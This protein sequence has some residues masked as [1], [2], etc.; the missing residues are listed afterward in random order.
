LDPNSAHGYF[1]KGAI[2]VNKGNMREAVEDLRLAISFDPS[3]ADALLQ[4][5]RVYVSSGQIS[6][7]AS[8]GFFTKYALQGKKKKALDEVTPQ[9]ETAAKGVEYLS[10]DMAHGYAMIDEKDKALDWLE[11]AANRGFIAYPFLNEFDPFLKNIR[12]EERF[13][14]LMER[15]KYE[16]ENFKV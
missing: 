7:A 3:N 15:V 1:L 6:A 16:W 13:K 5:A 11:N 8:L 4:L 12:S 9:L 14:K 10:R 2:Q